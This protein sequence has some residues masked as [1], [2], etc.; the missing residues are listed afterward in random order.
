MLS[1]LSI[2]MAKTKRSMDG[3][4]YAMTSR[5][6]SGSVSKRMGVIMSIT[7]RIIMPS[8]QKNITVV[9]LDTLEANRDRL[10]I[11]KTPMYS[12][13]APFTKLNTSYSTSP[14]YCTSVI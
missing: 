14:E 12:C 13:R 4:E 11:R 5:M 3:I 2:T 6:N 7:L 1:V 8:I 9:L 10:M